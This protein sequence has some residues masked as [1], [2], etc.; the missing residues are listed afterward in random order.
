MS[1]NAVTFAQ[2][3]LTMDCCGKKIEELCK[4][5][6]PNRKHGNNNFPP[7]YF[8]PYHRRPYPPGSKLKT[9]TV[10]QRI[11]YIFGWLPRK[12]RISRGVI[13]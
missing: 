13:D 1:K 4:N 2:K 3:Y 10:L 7:E 11:R 9:S 12:R 5:P 8:V 6:R